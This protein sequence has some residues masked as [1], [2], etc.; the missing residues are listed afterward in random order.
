M[1]Q[2][3]QLQDS[4]FFLPNIDRIPCIGLKSWKGGMGRDRGTM[5]TDSISLSHMAFV[6]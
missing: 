5:E 1:P 3:R 2:T 4:A 6:P